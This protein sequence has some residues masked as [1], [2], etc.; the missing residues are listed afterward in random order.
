[1]IYGEALTL[2]SGNYQESCES[3]ELRTAQYMDG[4]E[5]GL[6]HLACNCYDLEG[7]KH[8]SSFDLGL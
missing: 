3:C 2:C 1:M 4:E 8:E 7:R 5:M 6:C